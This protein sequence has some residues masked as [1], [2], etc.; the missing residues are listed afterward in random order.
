MCMYPGVRVRESTSASFA[1]LPLSPGCAR[2]DLATAHFVAGYPTIVFWPRGASVAL[3]A[4]GEVYGGE[5]S[6]EVL[7]DFINAKT[8]LSVRYTKGEQHIV[9]LTDQNFEKVVYDESKNVLVKF[10]APWC[11]HCRRLAPEYEEVAR[12]FK[13]EDSVVIAK[14]DAD[15]HKSFASIHGV[16]GYPTVRFFPS[17]A[18]GK[19]RNVL[20]EGGRDAKS[21]VS[22]V[23]HMSGT[24]RAPGGGLVAGAGL[25]NQLQD[26]VVTAMK[27]GAPAALFPKVL[28]HGEIERSLPR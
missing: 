1:C 3:G 24:W 2:R 20:Y 12:A 13:D 26:I 17:G 18:R 14:Y 4:K 19:D 5:R 28:S 22:Y 21:M 8:G 16:S 10:Y 15:M 25:I 6:T 7:V 27:V 9:V 11:G 23:N